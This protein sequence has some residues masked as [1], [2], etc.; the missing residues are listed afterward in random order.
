LVDADNCELERDESGQDFSTLWRESYEN[1]RISLEENLFA[2]DPMLRSTLRIWTKYSS[3]LLI[4]CEA[5]FL[6]LGRPTNIDALLELFK[7]EIDKAEDKLASGW[8]MEIVDLAGANTALKESADVVSARFRALNSLMTIHLRTIIMQSAEAYV[9]SLENA[10]NNKLHFVVNCVLQLTPC[11][12][13]SQATLLSKLLLGLDMICGALAAVAP[14]DASMAGTTARFRAQPATEFKDA[15][16]NRI[17]SVVAK[18]FEPANEFLI[19]HEQYLRYIVGGAAEQEVDAFL[20]SN[21]KFDEYTALIVTYDTLG[22]E[23]QGLINIFVCDFI[24]MNCVQLNT[25]LRARVLYLRQLIENRLLSDYRTYNNAICKGFERIQSKALQEPEDSKEMFEL[26]AYMDTTRSTQIPA[27]KEQLLTSQKRMGILLNLVEFIPEDIT[28]NSNALLWPTNIIPVFDENALLLERV[29]VRGEESLVAKK[30]KTY[31]EL[32]KMRKRLSELNDVGDVEAMGVCARDVMTVQKR[33]LELTTTVVLI[34]KEETL[35]QT[36]LSNYPAIKELQTAIVPF[37]SLFNEILRWQ[38][39]WKRWM[40]GSMADLNPDQIIQDVDEFWRESYK[41]AKSQTPGSPGAQLCETTK[42]EITEFKKHI[43]MMSILCNPGMRERH[44]IKVS[45]LVGINMQPDSSTTLRKLIDLKLDS[46]LEQIEVISGGASKEFSLEKAMDKMLREWEPMALNPVNKNGNYI[47]S[48]VDEIQALFDD[49]LVKTMTMRGSPFCKPFAVRMAAWEKTLVYNQDVIDG[50]LKVQATWMYLEPI[51]SSP[52]IRAQMPREGELFQNVDSVFKRLMAFCVETPAVLK[53]CSQEGMLEQINQSNINLELILKGLNE[54]LEKKRLYFSRFFFLSNDEMLEILSETK[55]PTRVQPHLKKCFEGICKLE[56]TK[57][58]DITHM[59]SGEGEK[60]PLI[61]VISTNDA[62]GSVE[63]WLLILEDVMKCTVRDVTDKARLAY[64]DEP[65]EEWVQHWPGQVAIAVGQTFWTTGVHNAIKGG[66]ETLKMFCKQLQD[67]LNEIVKLVR[68]RLPKQVRITLG[69]MVTLDVHSRD[70]TIGLSDD[71]ISSDADFAWLSQLRYYWENDDMRVRMI[72]S[73]CDYGYEYLGNTCRLVVTPLTD[74]CYRTLIGAYALH[75]GGAPEGPAGTGKTET[76]KDLAKAMAIQCVVFNCSDGLDYLAMGKFFKGLAS[77]G[78]WACFDE[79]NRIELEVLSVIATQIL[80]I[81]RAVDANMKRFV[82]EGTEL[83]LNVRCCVYITMNPGYAGR[84]E[85]P[86]N[87]K[88]LFRTVAMMVPDYTMIAEISLYSCGYVTARPLSVKITTT[89]KLCSEQLSSQFHYDYGMRAVKAVLSAAGNVKLKFPDESEEILLLRSI[90]DVNVP[91]FL[92]H[93]IPLFNGI[94]SDLF[95]GITLPEADYRSFNAAALETCAK[96]N[97]QPVSVCLQKLVETYEMMIVRHGFM[98]VGEPFAG[99]TS[100][101]KVLAGT[102]TLLSQQFAGVKDDDGDPLYR[103]ANYRIVNP[104][105]ITMGQLFGCF[106]AVSHE[107]T[108]GVVAN[109]FREFAM[110][111]AEYRKW[112]VF[113]GPIDTLWI[114][115]MNTVLDDNKKLCLMSGEIIAM[116]NT[117]SLIFETADLSQASPATVSRCGMVYMEPVQLGWRPIFLSWLNTLHDFLGPVIKTLLTE[118]FDAILNPAIRLIRKSCVELCP[119]SD[120]MLACSLMRLIM[121]FTSDFKDESNVKLHEGWIRSCFYFCLV[122]SVGATINRDGR[123]KFDLFVKQQALESDKAKLDISF[124]E[125]GTVYDYLFEKKG[126]G[127]WLKWMQTINNELVIKPGMKIKDAIVPTLDTARY[128]YLMDLTLRNNCPVVFV[129]PT[130]TGKSVYIKDKLMNGLEKDL[131]LPVIMN[132]SAQT[133]AQTTQNF[134]L[135]KLDKRRRGWFGPMMGKKCVILVDDMNMP[136]VEK[137][138]AQP[139]I[140]LLRQFLDQGNWYDFIETTAMNLVDVQIIGAMGPP[141]GGRSLV[142]SRFLRHLNVIG[143]NEFDEDTMQRIFKTITARSMRDNQFPGDA[144]AM[145]DVLVTSTMLVYKSAIE[146][147]LPTPAKSH[148]TFNLRDFSRVINGVLLVSGKVVGDKNKLCRL[149]CHE[150]FRVFYDRLI[151]DA[152]RG[153]FYNLIKT[154]VKDNF[155]MNFDTVFSGISKGKPPTED[156]FRSLLF[157]DYMVAGALDRVYDEVTDLD[158]FTVVAEAGLEEYNNVNKN[159]MDL[160]VFRYVLEHLS[161]ISRVLKQDGGHALLVGVGG[162]GRQSMTRL[163]AALA[164]YSF[165]QPEITKQYGT[166]E[167][168]EDIKKVLRKAG[169]EDKKIVFL[170]NDT[171]IKKESF[172]EDIDAL[173]NSGEVSNIFAPEEKAE[174]CELVRAA[175][176]V[177][178]NTDELNPMQLYTYFVSRCRDNLHV[179]L[180]MSPLGTSFSKRLRMFPSLVNCCTIDWFQSWPVDALQLVAKKSLQDVEM[181]DKER[182]SVVTLCQHFHD[183]S[184][185][186]SVKFR[187]S[188][189]RYNYVTPTSYLALV[190]AFKGLLQNKRDSIMKIRNQY[191]TGLD[192]LGNASSQVAALQKELTEMQPKLVVAQEENAKM[193][194]VIANDSA[195]AAVIETRV[196]IDEA[197]ANEKASLAST[198]K[199][200]CEAIL[201]EAIPALEAAVA[202]LNTLKKADIDLVKSF[203]SPPASVRLVMEAVCVM[204]EVAPEKVNDPSGSGKKILDY[205]GPAKKML[206]DLK[207]LDALKSYDKDNI[208]VEVI[209]KIRETYMDDPEFVPEKI[210]NASSACEGLCKWV[211]AL[212]TYDRVAKVVAPKKAALKV[213]E[214]EVTVLMADLAGKQAELKAVTDKLQLLNDNLSVAVKSKEELEFKVNLCA[215]KLQRAEK[216]IGGLG[217]EQKRWADAAESL[218]VAYNNLTGDVLISSGVIAY[219]GAFTSS[220]RNDCVVDWVQASKKHNLP[221]SAKFSLMETLGDPVLVRSWNIEGLPTDMFSINN[222]IIMKNSRRWPLMIDPQGQANKWI[223]NIE[224]A[225][226]LVVVKLTD[227]TYIRSLENA[228]QFGTPVLMENVPDE[229]DPSLE[230]VLLKQTFKQAGAICI[231]LGENILEYSEDFR[232][233]ITTKL[234]NPHYMP[235][236]STKVTLLNFMITPEGLEDQLLGIVVAKER[237][238]LEEERQQLILQSA[239]NKKMLKEIESRI[240]ETLS[241]SSGNILEDESAIKVLDEA[242]IVSDEI[243]AKQKVAEVTEIKINESRAGYKSVAQHSAVLFFSTSDMSNIDPMYQYSLTWFVGLFIN[244]IQDS[245]KS[246]VLEKRLRFLTDHFTY[247]L[248][249]AVCRSLFEKDKLLFSFLLTTNLLKMRNGMDQ[250]EFMFFLTGGVGLDNKIPNPCPSWITKKVWDELCRMQDGLPGFK[251]FLDSFRS[252]LPLWQ[253]IYDSKTPHIAVLP[254]PWSE[255]LSDF[256]RMIA[257]RVL[258]PDKVLQLARLFVEQKLGKNF[259]LPPPFDLSKSYLDSSPIS[260]LIFVL[261]PGADPMAG[262]LKFA[263]DQGMGGEKFGAISLG[264][265][266]GVPAERMIMKAIE[267]GN[268]V[269]L[270]NCHLA[271]S[272]MNSLERICEGFT[273]D[274]CHKNFRLWLTSYPSDRF[275]VS[276][277]Q[278][279]CKMTNEPPTGLRMNLLQ[280]Y[281]NDPVS[282]PA[283]Y[284]KLIDKP[285]AHLAFQKLLIGMCFF[286]ALV[287]ERRKFGPLGWNIAYGFNESDLRISVRQLNIFLDDYEDIPYDALQYLTGHCNYGGRVTDDW[288]RRCLISILKN[289]FNKKNV[290]ESKYSFSQSGLYHVPTCDTYEGYVNFIKELPL[291]QPP[292][293]FGMHDNV[294]MSKELQET[295]ILFDSVLCTQQRSGGGSSG[296]SDEMATEIANDII[297]RLPPPFDTEEALNRF[298]TRYDESMNTVLVQEMQRFNKLVNIVSSTLKGLLKAMKGLVVMSA[299]LEDVSRSLLVGKIPDVWMKYS[300]P[301]LKPLGSYINDFLLRLEMLNNWF[302]STKPNIFWISGFFFTQAFLTGALQNYAR[303]VKIPIDILGFDFEVLSDTEPSHPP[304]DGVYVR[305]LFVDGARWDRATHTLGESLPKVLFDPMPILWLK[306]AKK[307]DFSKAQNY[308]CPVYKTSIRKGVLATT[309]HSSNYVLPIRLPSLQPEDHWIRRG[310]ALLCQLDD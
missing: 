137:Y 6:V 159:P 310:V 44:W 11:F 242:K 135:S 52:D 13:P 91:K 81:Q 21:A 79:F 246:K 265:G 161:R 171:Q 25:S 53:A 133:S 285:K 189:G 138:G 104:K 39:T 94:I 114:E 240:L 64:S 101:L 76:T 3:S 296:K 208:K 5:L 59:F 83:D 95:P 295:R 244:S 207:F 58:L 69:A 225:N 187:E 152:D 227:A 256:Q 123:V 201:A 180:G 99:K 266:Q 251:G 303:K 112:I 298:P 173:L 106:D 37:A 157:G 48:S 8:Y 31:A 70:V 194:V 108:D 167:W 41:L 92:S 192:K 287:Q 254:A 98:L 125:E 259:T 140:E 190:K 184:R 115:S 153:W 199:A 253:A 200:D 18:Y 196:R 210:A 168:K 143:I 212:S 278:N 261:S 36:E 181:T 28:L 100:V 257:I 241:N 288:D 304:A 276:V 206:G 230:S 239:S 177:A 129:G 169:C 4:D 127:K 67:E 56:F 271:V 17:K 233:Y 62:K 286:H 50:W 255:K 27:L 186:Q 160:I 252:N 24:D 7:S 274:S 205:W 162:S 179:I 301:S 217:G 113:D 170:M 57:D 65:R 250:Q 277:L 40:D 260:P 248:Y 1:C 120:I 82:F 90:V 147:L 54:Y 275:P 63:K 234:P 228:I 232:F 126:K 237:P 32:D 42:K 283:F 109:T 89:Y 268:W 139:P 198:E 119:S 195:D 299:D 308:N 78:A 178:M 26:I 270:Q 218:L 71:G 142:T 149:W 193:M 134:I 280:S 281:L 145:V 19:S 220:F 262:L 176:T 34:N 267:E 16:R 10:P 185:I 300:Y 297:K 131:F 215:S 156:D 292:E 49:H 158:K 216:L 20:A 151:D 306:P 77:S 14:V 2:T 72:N 188:A 12:E 202:A 121:A 172:L 68:G 150:A 155:K 209:S 154:V 305:G 166:E 249:C 290:E 118:L 102:L 224:K 132:F 279:G 219:L 80:T 182:A 96:L 238:E 124:P 229:L 309:G 226:K 231:K 273:V 293:A 223:K 247:N 46:F 51:F 107:W 30:D 204:R 245:N 136:V 130:G 243:S 141:G 302:K 87:L 38:K 88:V 116:S 75:L 33:L 269:C 164:D 236:T 214:A 128:T 117:M 272:W 15:L 291:E 203:K 235:E 22:L 284:D 163:A 264:Q 307:E 165:F 110:N 111:T 146:G 93:D 144:Q 9:K 289:S 175:A 47:L 29:K 84:S 263:E 294:D 74:R 23:L 197:A 60:V 55:D 103:G 211:R 122:W 86:D 213:K 222:G 61:Q 282:D 73:T 258:R 97:L 183:S 221:C 45:E 191:V 35:F 105:S 174:I 43:N 85:L 66:K 148:Y